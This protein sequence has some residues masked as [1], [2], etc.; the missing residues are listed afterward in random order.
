LA[1]MAR[2]DEVYGRLMEAAYQLLVSEGPAA[3]T[4]RRIAGE[5]GMSTMN[6]YSRFGDKDGIIEQLFVRGY[7]ILADTVVAPESPDHPVEALREAAFALRRFAVANTSLYRLMFLGAVP[8][9][10]PSRAA[11]HL[12]EAAIAEIATSFATCMDLGLIRRLDPIH[13]ALGQW[14]VA[15]GAIS[16]ELS[17]LGTLRVD[18]NGAFQTAIDVFFRGLAP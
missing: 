9:Y 14:S 1:A 8:D 6:V 12:G 7:G 18:W 16:L 3:L 13:V 2:N 11:M 10:V 5:A 17:N 4:V 15:H